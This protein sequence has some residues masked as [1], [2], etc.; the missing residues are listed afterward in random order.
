MLSFLYAIAL[1]AAAVTA[2]YTIGVVIAPAG[3]RV[4]AATGGP[5]LLNNTDYKAT[6]AQNAYSGPTNMTPRVVVEYSD[7]SAFSNIQS[8]LPSF[9]LS[10]RIITE[11][12]DFATEFSMTQAPQ[13]LNNTISP[14]IMIEYADYASNLAFPVRNYTGPFPTQ[15]ITKVAFSLSPNPA[16]AGRAVTVLGNLTT[17][18]NVPIANAQMTVKANGTLIA[19]LTTNATGWVKTS[20]NF[21]NAG[22][23]NVTVNYAG[24][25]QYSPSSSWHLL[26]VNPKPTAI[27]AIFVPNPVS[28]NASYQLNG[29]IVDNFSIPVVSATI[30]L[31]ISSNYGSTWTSLG[32]VTTNS[33]GLFSKNM[34]APAAGA[35]VFRLHY[36]G[37]QNFNP[38]TTVISLAVH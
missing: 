26:V 30:S 20:H 24:S 22:V 10:P 13:A 18:A 38:T 31:E 16:F 33:Y 21:V 37:S 23:Y 12:A 15:N 3:M 1:L 7:Y 9:S 17:S 27:Y 28:P 2:F 25:D 36:G 6:F 29:I 5:I 8:G 14:R 11:Y 32:T 19:T 4:F 34:T 35:Y